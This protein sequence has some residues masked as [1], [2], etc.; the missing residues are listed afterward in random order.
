M[1]RF[2]F[3]QDLENFLPAEDAGQTLFGLRFQDFEDMPIFFKNML[4]EKLDSAI[5]YSQG[6]RRPFVHI[7]LMEKIKKVLGTFDNSHPPHRY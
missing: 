4:I 2:H 3:G 5:A 1:K 6:T 7:A